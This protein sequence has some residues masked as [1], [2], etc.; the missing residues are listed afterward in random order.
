M[1]HIFHYL[2][3]DFYL[4]Q[5]DFRFLHQILFYL[6]HLLLTYDTIP[7]FCD[8]PNSIFYAT[9]PF[10][11]FIAIYTVYRYSYLCNLHDASSENHGLYLN[12]GG[13]VLLLQHN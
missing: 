5:R 7:V 10:L 8:Q 13:T 11:S 1:R 6:R 12:R 3:H 9:H 2:R 4:L